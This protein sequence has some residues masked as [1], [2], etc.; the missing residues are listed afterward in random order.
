[1]DLS[2]N[3]LSGELPALL[4]FMCVLSQCTACRWSLFCLPSFLGS[5]AAVCS[6]CSGGG[7]VILR[8]NTLTGMIPDYIAYDN[9]T[10]YK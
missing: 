9:D 8:N 2:N 10:S 6:L 3:R 1:M 4:P 7:E 5:Y